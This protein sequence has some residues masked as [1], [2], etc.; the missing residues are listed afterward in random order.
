MTTIVRAGP[1]CLPGVLFLA[2]GL[3]GCSTVQTVASGVTASI[4]SVVERIAHPATRATPPQAA[5]AGLDSYKTQVAQH[6]VR[7]NPEHNYN[8]TLPPLLPAI[9]VL[10]ITVDRNGQLASVEVQRSRS[11]DASQVALAAMRRSTPLP[12]P[13]QLAQS[14]GKLTFSETFLFAD[15][16]RYQLRSLAGPQASE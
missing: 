3:S 14:T 15:R 5:P 4:G 10:E 8:G 7:H 9:V 1:A 16:E 2:A 12:P 13:Q 6:V 11:P